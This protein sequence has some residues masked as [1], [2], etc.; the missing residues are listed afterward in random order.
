MFTGF[1][2]FINRAKD[3]Y[4]VFMQASDKNKI[5]FVE[6]FKILRAFY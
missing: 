2:Y 5:E 3:A 1:F 6:Q 4:D